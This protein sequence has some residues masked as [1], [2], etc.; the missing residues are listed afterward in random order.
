[1]RS[2]DV[3]IAALAIGAPLKWADNTISQ[4][5]VE[6][7]VQTRRGIARRVSFPGLVRLAVI[8]QLH[9]DL[10]V[11]VKDG[12]RIAGELL[13]SETV[14]VHASGHLLLTVNLP[15]L[16]RTLHRRLADALESAPSP[17]RGRPPRGR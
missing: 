11:S 4:H 10:G 15:E 5:D 7:V 8:R 9:V 6:G 14:G 1:M 13:D 17:R 12:V 3:V 2:Y 16:E